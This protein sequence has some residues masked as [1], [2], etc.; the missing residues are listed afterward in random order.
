MGFDGALGRG[1]E[2]ERG[3]GGSGNVG[4]EMLQ[5]G[6]KRVEIVERWVVE[7]TRSWF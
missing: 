4:F 1:E 2:A 5:V 7:S 3:V 6:A